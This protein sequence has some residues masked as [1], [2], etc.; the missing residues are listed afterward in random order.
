MRGAQGLAVSQEHRL[1]FLG[2]HLLELFV[3][4]RGFF[5]LLAEFLGLP[6][7]IDPVE[8]EADEFAEILDKGG[9]EVEAVAG[10]RGKTGRN[11][12]GLIR[13]ACGFLPGIT[14]NIIPLI[15]L[16]AQ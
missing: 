7:R 5:P 10:G 14:G 2:Q 4:E 9:V 1:A 15:A 13:I 12:M 6:A 3:E 16:S 11:G 8:A